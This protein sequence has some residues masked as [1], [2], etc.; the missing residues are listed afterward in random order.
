M[1][2]LHEKID[3]TA[4]AYI[5]F[6]DKV[7][8]R[9]HEK[10]NLWLP[11]GGHIEVDEGIIEALY[12]EVKEETGLEVDIIG[13]EEVKYA[14]GSSDL[15][16]PMV[17]NRHF[18]DGQ[19]EHIDFMYVVRANSDQI[20]P[21]EDEMSNADGFQWFTKEGLENNQEIMDRVK[22]HALKA[23]ELSKQHD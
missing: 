18:T 3:F 17:I 23:L 2:H 8:L 21:A 19:H 7:L 14:D 16:M 22:G 20:N 10:Y 4:S 9:N 6:E 12:R 1:P 11:P 15:P 5:I 13:S